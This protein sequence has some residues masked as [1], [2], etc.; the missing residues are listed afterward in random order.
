MSAADSPQRTAPLA[1]WRIA[2]AFL[3]AATL[4]KLIARQPEKTIIHMRALYTG[5]AGRDLRS[6]ASPGTAFFGGERSRSD[7]AML[8][9]SASVAAIDAN[10]ADPVLP[11][12]SSLFDRFGVT[13]PAL[14]FIEAELDRMR[15]N[16]FNAEGT[17]RGA[18]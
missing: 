11:L 9:G 17:T 12:V 2:E 18:R 10:L 3:H 1:L 14:P 15:Q 4:T 13:G 16:H 5:L 8:E 6:W 7:E